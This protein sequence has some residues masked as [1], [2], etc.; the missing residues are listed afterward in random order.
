MAQ[1]LELWNK[2]DMVFSTFSDKILDVLFVA[3]IGCSQ[4]RMRLVFIAIVDLC[5]DYINTEIG[6]LSYNFG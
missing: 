5:Y 6:E 4:L 3:W 2:A 1:A